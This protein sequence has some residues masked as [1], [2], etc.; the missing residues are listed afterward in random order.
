MGVPREGESRCHQDPEPREALPEPGGAARAHSP[1]LPLS[2]CHEGRGNTC[3]L[4]LCPAAVPVPISPG[5]LWSFGTSTGI[6]RGSVT[7]AGCPCSGR[8]CR[9]PHSSSDGH[10]CPT[11]TQ[12]GLGALPAPQDPLHTRAR[13]THAPIHP[14][15]AGSKAALPA[16]GWGTSPTGPAP[17]AQ[18]RHKQRLQPSASCT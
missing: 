9:G 8:A 7:S 5:L 16:A 12:E 2:S 10:R 18:P 4:R 17:P 14:S 3:K 11:G 1:P 13:T 15:M 6:S